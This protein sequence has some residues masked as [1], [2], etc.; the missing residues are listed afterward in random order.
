MSD[1]N[2]VAQIGQIAT[3]G[4]HKER[5]LFVGTI[6]PK[7]SLDRFFY[8]IEIDS[9]WVDGEKIKNAIVNTFGDSWSNSQRDKLE[10]FESSIKKINAK[11]GEISQNGE[12]E[13]IGKLNAI[14][15]ISSGEELI[16]SQTGK[17]SGYL[18][19][20]NKISH[21]TEKPVETDEIHPLK[22]FVS[23][24][25]GNVAKGD[26]V[27]IANSILY[28]H[29]SLDRLRQLFSLLDYRETIAEISKILRR[30]KVK[31]VNLISFDI[32]DS[33]EVVVNAENGDKPNII[34]LDDLPDS[35]VAHYSKAFIRGGSK[36]AK[37]VGRGAKKIAEFWSKSVAPK[38][39]E[40]AKTVGSKAKII[41]SSGFKPVTEKFDSVPRVNYFNRKTGGNSNFIENTK[42]FF[43]NLA[44]WSKQL[45]KP[46]NRKYLYIGLIVILLGIGFIKIQMNSSKGTNLKSDTQSVNSLD[47]ARSLYAKALDDLGLKREGGK[48]KLIQARDEAKKAME[49]VAIKDE[50]RNLLAQIQA[51][52]DELN[53]A[54]RIAVNKEA[55]YSL[56]GN[57]PTIYA[58]GADIYSFDT[59][60]KISKYDTRKKT[61]NTVT[62]ISE[63]SGKIKAISYSDSQNTFFM[64]TDK[65]I[66]V[67]FD[68]ASSGVSEKPVTDEGGVWEN[69]VSLA[70]FTTN[71]YLLDSEV[72]GIWKHTKTDNGFSK[73]SAYVPKQPIPLKS[74][75]DIAID[76]DVYVL[77]TDGTVIKIK[78][79][80]EDTA[81]AIAA[82]PSPDTAIKSPTKLYTSAD[83]SSI[84]IFDKEANRVLEFAK[85]GVYKRQFVADSELPLSGFSV[86]SKLKKIWLLSGTKV[87]ELDL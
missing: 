59:D 58:V 76:G 17:I 85:T 40:K 84:F 81:F 80:V 64:L 54:T 12:H 74:S 51:K 87:F 27:I 71:L 19:R 82:A 20:G 7:D 44:L 29:L 6:E 63:S 50:A 13:W 72:G 37:A 47:S 32:V 83:S 3:K 9:P 10:I 70:S 67:Q 31:D 38:I 43:A 75:V 15:G 36:G 68:V 5:F 1:K 16:F 34:V 22:T 18:F 39:S 4:K 21:I 62:S 79:S 66:I 86:N 73:G 35:K 28:S 77:K 49:S 69:S 45:I 65:S 57:S 25:N 11:L 55:S 14:V 23:I 78:K 8:L 41:S 53:I 48:E 46:E 52:L 60:G 42:R 24:I 26:K 56:S 61:L 2:L 33:E 30:I